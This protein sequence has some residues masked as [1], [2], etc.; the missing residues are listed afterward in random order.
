MTS[1]RYQ[2]LWIKED[3]LNVY[4]SEFHN[5]IVIFVHLWFLTHKIL[6]LTG[7]ITFS[8][9]LFWNLIQSMAHRTLIKEEKKERNVLYSIVKFNFLSSCYGTMDLPF[10][11]SLPRD[12]Q[13]QDLRSTVSYCCG[14]DLEFSTGQTSSWEVQPH[15]FS[16]FSQ[17]EKSRTGKGKV[18]APA[19]AFVR[20]AFHS[21]RKEVPGKRTSLSGESTQESSALHRQEAP[22][23]LGASSF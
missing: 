16:S 7:I 2:W 17:K 8:G 21:A 1:S 3:F 20:L 5:N 15:L 4:C 6:V 14:R 11:Q 19:L 10:K 13:D 23:L 12:P 22:R 9:F 18:S